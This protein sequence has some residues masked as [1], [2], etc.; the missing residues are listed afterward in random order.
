MPGRP[1]LLVPKNRFRIDKNRFFAIINRYVSIP[2]IGESKSTL[3]NPRHYNLYQRAYLGLNV[4][5]FSTISF[6]EWN[7]HF[8]SAAEKLLWRCACLT[9]ESSLFLLHGR[10]Q[11]HMFMN[12]IMVVIII[13]QYHRLMVTIIAV[14]NF[15]GSYQ[16][17]FYLYQCLARFAF[18]PL[19]P[20]PL[21]PLPPL[22]GKGLILSSSIPGSGKPGV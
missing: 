3:R 4:I 8:P 17:Q 12:T 18:V 21:P 10:H 22:Q 20:D 2:L 14:I 11:F 7:L 19:F 1:A 9:A 6:I 5:C 16:Q 15:Y 13:Y